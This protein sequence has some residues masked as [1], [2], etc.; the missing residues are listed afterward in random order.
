MLRVLDA[1]GLY[2][3]MVLLRIPLVSAAP[4]PSVLSARV[5]ARTLAATPEDLASY[6]RLRPDTSAA[7]VR[8]RLDAGAICFVTVLD[9]A[10]VAAMW[11]VEQN[12]HI[13]Y[14][15][16]DLELG[17]GD[18][19]AFDVFTA[20]ALRGNDLA[21]WSGERMRRH[22]AELGCVRLVSAQLPENVSAMTRSARRGDV[23]IGTVGVVALGP[24]RR[25]FVRLAAPRTEEPAAKVVL[26]SCR[27]ARGSA[28][29]HEF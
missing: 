23:R 1:L 13:D 5:M 7:G 4:Q 17:R 20:P 12:A 15:G 8:A 18:G 16:C 9:G 19:Y 14:L 27:H 25:P 29:W 28:G 11:A 10:M 2:R 22:M 24:W 3:R 21:S 26:R 6:A